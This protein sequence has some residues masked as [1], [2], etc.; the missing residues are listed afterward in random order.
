MRL[1]TA[2]RVQW[3]YRHPPGFG[4]TGTRSQ[5][6][7]K[8]RQ[9]TNGT[10]A[11]LLQ[12]IGPLSGTTHLVHVSLQGQRLGHYNLSSNGFYNLAP[13]DW[14]W[15]DDGTL[16]LCGKANANATNYPFRAYLARWDL[17]QTPL[18]ARQS[19]STS[20]LEALEA[21]P[22]PATDQM[23]VRVARPAK[24][25]RLVVT[26]VDGRKVSELAVPDSGVLDVVTADLPAGVYWLRLLSSTQVGAG[27]R[28]AIVR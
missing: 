20:R 13:F 7:F 11:F 28:I 1:D 17:R 4:G 23:R 6:A 19:T 22:N 24:G 18:A 25:L 8:V 10:L 21:W 16:L 5:R 14:L 12:D 3:V 26:A 2:L 15:L 27:C 9:L